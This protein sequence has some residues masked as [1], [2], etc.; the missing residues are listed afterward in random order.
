MTPKQGIIEKRLSM[1][2]RLLGLSRKEAAQKLGISQ[3]TLSRWINFR[4][5]ITPL[6]VRLL[7][8][9]GISKQAIQYPGEELYNGYL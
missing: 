4:K 6:G 2:I 5:P 3:E 8:E 7:Q 1:E 9:M